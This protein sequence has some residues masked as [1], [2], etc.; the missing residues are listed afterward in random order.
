MFFNSFMLLLNNFIPFIEEKDDRIVTFKLEDYLETILNDE[1][2]NFMIE[3]SKTMIFIR[4][5]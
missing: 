3:M 2:K 4:L 1:H 5:C